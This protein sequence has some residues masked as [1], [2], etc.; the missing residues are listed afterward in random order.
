MEMLNLNKYMK[1]VILICAVTLFAA[2]E[3]NVKSDKIEVNTD[4]TQVA[5]SLHTDS[6]HVDSLNV[7]K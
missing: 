1:K 7:K 3:F 5:D 4:S 6:V 2:C